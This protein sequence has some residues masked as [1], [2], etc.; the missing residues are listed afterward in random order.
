MDR[1][2]KCLLNI[3][4]LSGNSED[5]LQTWLFSLQEISHNVLIL[6]V[7]FFYIYCIHQYFYVLLFPQFIRLKMVTKSGKLEKIP[8]EFN[9]HA[10]DM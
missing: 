8:L 1:F 10:K 2:I 5:Y 7:L 9:I 3:Q 4:K 6:F